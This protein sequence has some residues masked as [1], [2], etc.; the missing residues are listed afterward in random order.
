MYTFNKYIGKKVR[1]YI[2]MLCIEDK[3]YHLLTIYEHVES[4]MSDVEAY[5]PNRGNWWLK[6]D[7]KA[8]SKTGKVYVCVEYITLTEAL[9]HSPWTET[10]HLPLTDNYKYGVIKH[11]GEDAIHLIEDNPHSIVH[12]LP[13]RNCA[14]Y[15]S[16]Y[17]PAEQ[18]E[19]LSQWLSDEKI[20]RQLTLLSKEC[21][22][23]DICQWEKYIGQYIFVSYNPI[24]RHIHWREDDKDPGVYCR[25]N[26]RKGARQVLKFKIEGYDNAGG[27][28]FEQNQ[29]SDAFIN[30]FVFDKSFSYLRVFVYDKED[31]LIDYY[32]RLNF[33]HQINMDMRLHEKT[34]RIQNEDGEVI[35]EVEKF[36]AVDSFN[37]GELLPESQFEED[38]YAYKSLEDTLDFVFIEGDRNGDDTNRKKGIDIIK[39][40]LNSAKERCFICDVYFGNQDFD[41]FILDMSLLNVRVNI[42]TSK[43]AF[44]AEKTEEMLSTKM[45]TYDERTGGNVQCKLLTGE[46]ILHDRLIIADDQVWML[47]SSL[48]HFGAKATTLIRVPREYKGKLV[49]EIE[50]LWNSDEESRELNH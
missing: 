11:K 14:A 37:I 33:V 46:P 9:Y 39:R 8:D 21:F 32:P 40:I 15:I 38:I 47:G 3:Y 31:V 4:D 45:V 36:S 26:F 20:R 41:D 19:R 13:S 34:V 18:I 49:S 44:S 43:L 24:Y 50:R 10:G 7:E 48:N 42:L 28:L 29:S 30:K 2:F 1:R 6:R 12:I 22:G 25:I 23:F 27:K 35:K 5:K 16:Y 17:A